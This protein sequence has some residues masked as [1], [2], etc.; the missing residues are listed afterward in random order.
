MPGDG[1][2][3]EPAGVDRLWAALSG[4]AADARADEAAQGRA[5]QAW[6]RREA[7]S[8]ATLIG[9][10][11][12][13]A[14]R[15]A[16]VVI[17]L[18]AGDHTARGRL[19]A[20]GDDFA[21]LSTRAGHLCLVATAAIVAVRA[22]GEP[23]LPEPLGDRPPPLTTGLADALA[24]LAAD[25]P[26]VQLVVMPSGRTVAGQLVSVGADLVTVQ[27][28]GARPGQRGVPPAAVAVALG[29]IATCQ[30]T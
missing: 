10:L 30:L 5:R 16:D 8:E 9:L 13:L 28:A 14:E 17:D 12:D 23:Q 20:V 4:W 1:G 24:L 26:P 27:P 6:L 25:R 22:V 19:R 7:A 21:V 18:A 11:V 2:A 29:A 3:D 15:G